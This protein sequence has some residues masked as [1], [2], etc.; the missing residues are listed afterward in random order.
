[1]DAQRGAGAAQAGRALPQLGS[2]H[3]RGAPFSNFYS[4]CN[5][6]GTQLTDC[7]V[8]DSKINAASGA[9]AAR[10]FNIADMSGGC[11]NAHFYANTTGTYSYDA[12]TPDPMV[13][14]SCEN[15]GLHNGANGK[16][17]TTQYTN[18]M[19]DT[20]YGAQ[21]SG[22]APPTQPACDDDCGGHGTTY[23][24]QNFPGPG[25][26]AKNDDGTPMHNWWVYLFY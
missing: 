7:I 13:L 11:G 25:T 3:A 8:W 26:A 18:A 22:P 12:N 17:Q 21:H 24:Y 4:A 19:T 23:L 10:V 16:D 2:Q 20:L 6:N 15:Y 14:S 5:S 1:M 9:T